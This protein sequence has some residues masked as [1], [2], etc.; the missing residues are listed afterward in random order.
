MALN[1]ADTPN[2]TVGLSLE[3]YLRIIRKWYGVGLLT[4]ERAKDAVQYAK[5]R[6]QREDN[7][8]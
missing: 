1:T 4:E 2:M 7:D 8:E 5:E 3:T 6:V